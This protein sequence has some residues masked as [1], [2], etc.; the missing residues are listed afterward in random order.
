MLLQKN[1]LLC[2]ILLSCKNDDNC[3]AVIITGVG[4]KVFSAGA[5]LNTFMGIMPKPFGG[6]EWSRD[7]QAV[8]NIIEQL[9]KPSIAAI[10]GLAIGGGFELALAC[11]FRIASN[12]AKF[13]FP[14]ITLGFFPGW[15]GTVRAT[16]LIGKSKAAELILMGELIDA[17][18]ALQMGIVNKIVEKKDILLESAAFANKIIKNSAVA[19][20]FAM[21]AIHY[22]SEAS[23]DEALII[24]SNL[25]GLACNSE[26]ANEGLQ[27]FLG[28]RTPNFKGK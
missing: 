10:N 9:G 6:R 15:G 2:S 28:K 16:R 20:K 4:E 17:Q 5:D 21:E 13:G 18:K 7:G 27:A 12:G 26:D 14:E 24:E 3:R 11:T 22:V 23:F 19:V 25:A 8:L 1:H